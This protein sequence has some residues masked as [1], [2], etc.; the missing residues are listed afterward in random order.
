MKKRLKTIFI[1]ILIIALLVVPVIFLIKSFMPEKVQD[2]NDYV[3]NTYNI[4]FPVI[5]GAFTN[6]YT[7]EGTISTADDEDCTEIINI[8][9]T[10]ETSILIKP[11]KEFKKNQ[12]LY[13]VEDKEVKSKFDGKCISIENNK[14]DISIR[15]LDYSKI[16][17]L[18][19]IDYEHYKKI[20]TDTKTTVSVDNK[21]YN[22]TINYIDYNLGENGISVYIKI[23]D[24]S[25]FPIGLPCQI[26]FEL[27]K[28]KEALMLS[29]SAIIENGSDYYVYKETESGKELTKIEI[30]G[31]ST[32]EEDGLKQEYARI[33]SGLK[34]GDVAVIE[35]FTGSDVNLKEVFLDE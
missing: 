4:R 29:K 24:S 35:S 5:K 16:L 34:D 20:N 23:N 13:F 8:K 1:I 26:T 28:E 31:F 22:A 25:F 21:E 10:S 7:V 14:G 6:T 19:A 33:K 27:G 3:S 32:I 11:G 2:D 9:N 15:L 30:Y 12:T 18:T 17:V